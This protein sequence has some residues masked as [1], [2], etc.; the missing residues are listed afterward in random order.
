ML[1]CT[2]IY[3]LFLVYREMGNTLSDL[4][5]GTTVAQI[6]GI[7]VLSLEDAYEEMALN[8]T[9][10]QYLKSCTE[11]PPNLTAL[12]KIYLKPCRPP[13][14]TQAMS[15]AAMT[16]VPN[17][18]AIDGTIKV[19]VFEEGLPHTRA[20]KT[21]WFPES[22]LSKGNEHFNET[23]LHECIHLH[24][25]AHEDLWDK[26]Y[27]EQWNFI[28]YKGTIP[29]EVEERRRLNPDT[30]RAPF[31][32]WNGTGGPASVQS[33]GSDSE[34]GFASRGP[35]IPVAVYKKPDDADLSE[36]RL[37]FVRPDGSWSAVIPPGWMEFFRTQ[38]PSLCEHPHEMA[39][40]ILSDNANP[41]DSEAA[42]RLRNMYKTFNR[43]NK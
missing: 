29:R 22:L 23:F 15:N 11:S 33:T 14:N 4:P 6:M 41:F 9:E 26:F 5:G 39:A 2:A 28:R 20:P 3:H 31:Y 42:R 30:L 19:G 40:Y 38:N 10:D 8:E 17:S 25:R 35:Y 18:L 32:A 16:I 1:R 13:T 27:R 36:V 12:H 43:G 34:R 7:K 37:V 21:I 24:Q